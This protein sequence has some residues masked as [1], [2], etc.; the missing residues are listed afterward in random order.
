MYQTNIIIE[1]NFYKEK[2]MGMVQCWCPMEIYI[3]GLGWE[4]RDKEKGYFMKRVQ[5]HIIKEIGKMAKNMGVGYKKLMTN[6]FMTESLIRIWKVVWVSSFFQT[7]IFMKGVIKTVNLMVKVNIFGQM[8]QYIQEI[9]SKDNDKVSV[10]G[11][12]V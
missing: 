12:L 7:E 10:D 6:N 11:Y 8:D 1:D 4:D 5:I 2:D 9:L 3:K